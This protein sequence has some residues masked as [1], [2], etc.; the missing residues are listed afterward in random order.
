MLPSYAFAILVALLQVGKSAF[1]VPDK[2]REAK[3]SYWSDLAKEELHRR[4]TQEPNTQLAKNVII[5]LG[6]GMGI[7]TVTAARIYKGQKVECVSGEE[8]VLA[9][10]TFP[11]VSL[12]K[13]Y[14]LDAQ[15]S[16]SANTA[17]AYLCGVKA[18]I[19]TLGVDSSIKAGMCHANETSH[20]PSIMKWAQDS[21]KWTGVVTTTRVTEATPAAAY[22]HSG[23]RS[24]QS[25]VPQDCGAKDIAYQLV[26]QEPGSELRVVMGGGRDSFLNQTSKGER[27]YRVDGR[28]LTDD[29]VKN[30]SSTGKYVKTREELLRVNANE[31]DYI[32]GLFS[33]DSMAYLVNR[34]D[35]N[36]Q[37]PSL[38]EMTSKAL[39]L[40]T[41][42]P[43]GFVLLVEG[44]RI[45]HA[46]HDTRA[47]LALEETLEFERTVN[48]TVRR[49]GTNDTLIVV[50]ADHSHTMTI[51]GYPERGNNILG[52]AGY[53]GTG[54]NLA[55]TT[56][57]YANG[58]E[59]GKELK[60]LT[61][62]ETSSVE[63]VQPATFLRRRETHGGED[64]AVYAEGPWAHLFSGVHDQTFI[65][66]VLAFASCIGEFSGN[67]CNVTDT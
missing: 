11:Y 40:L 19:K 16:D 43:C 42:S 35:P 38:E 54:A 27:G 12:S 22:A 3:R 7:S 64:V 48:E 33:S 10:E 31:T 21:G 28:N 17:T 36:A 30:K 56:L 13:T 26:H 53:S 49:L 52:I 1:P 4:L 25:R 24:W 44:G 57:S 15:T 63:F 34:T 46:H 14:G 9:W 67:N 51:S 6:D 29:W 18:N 60:N 32:L 50:T 20:L 58:P 45:D 41:R 2:D 8:S 59:G 65:P 55:Y 23:H 47:H 61:E 5:F 37:Q 62:E 66:Y 39:D